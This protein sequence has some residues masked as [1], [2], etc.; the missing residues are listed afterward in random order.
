MVIR[1]AS[2]C[3]ISKNDGR[4]PRGPFGNSVMAAPRFLAP[5]V[6]VRVLVPE[7]LCGKRLMSI[8]TRS[9]TQLLQPPSFLAYVSMCS[10][11]RMLRCGSPKFE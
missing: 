9:K 3:P 11:S 10:R 7:L 5:L 1:L 8:A 4:V 2:S 6:Q